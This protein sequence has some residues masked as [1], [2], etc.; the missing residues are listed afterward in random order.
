MT[1]EER[2]TALVDFLSQRIRLYEQW[3]AQPDRYFM[4]A[5][6]D[7]V[8]QWITRY[9]RIIEYVGKEPHPVGLD[10]GV[11]A[12]RNLNKNDTT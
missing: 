1:D 4:G 12:F 2:I 3:L 10:R 5:H 6:K 7:M 11:Q 9:E 8:E